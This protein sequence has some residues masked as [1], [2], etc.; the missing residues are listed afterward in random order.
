MIRKEFTQNLPYGFSKYK[1][2]S[3]ETNEYTIYKNDYP[4]SIGYTYDKYIDNEEY[5]K[6]SAIEKQQVMLEA[7][8][9]D[10]K[11]VKSLAKED[12]RSVS[13]KIKYGT[14]TVKSKDGVVVKTDRIRSKKRRKYAD[15]F[16]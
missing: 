4:L 10:T 11:N 3:T 2:Y 15:S 14:V 7:A 5:E 6:L 8:V 9:L 12:T 1:D 13:D 16:I